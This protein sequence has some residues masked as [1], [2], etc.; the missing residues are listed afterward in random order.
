MSNRLSN[1]SS[2]ARVNDRALDKAEKTHG[3]PETVGL[4]L[5]LTKAHENALSHLQLALDRKSSGDTSTATVDT[6]AVDIVA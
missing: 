4:A 2:H 3:K 5:A 1:V 6:A